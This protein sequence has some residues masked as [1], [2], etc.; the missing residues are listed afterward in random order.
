M[1]FNVYHLVAMEDI[2]ELVKFK[3]EQSVYFGLLKNH[4]IYRINGDIFSD[5]IVTEEKYLLDDVKVL[6]PCRP[7][8]VIGIGL[9][10][11]DAIQK[12]K[13]AIPKEP[14]VFL[15]PPSSIIGPYDPI[16]YPSMSDMVTYEVELAVIIG[17]KAKNISVDNAMD[18][19][20]GYTVANDVT[21]KDLL[22][23]YG[24]WDIG[25]GFDTFL[26]LGPYIVTDIDPRNL[27]ITMKCNDVTTQNSNTDQ[28]IFDVSELISYTSHVMTLMPGDVIIT[29]TPAGASELNIGDVLEGN[30]EGLGTIK[31]TVVGG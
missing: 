7:S 17:K 30:I 1:Y 31:N 8:K 22:G 20:F 23:K 2:M 11:K 19:V 25:K 3:V 29:G 15:K 28:M 6:A 24:P 9:N 5:Y 14:I 13:T 21:A 10:Y 27:K 4:H 16:V 26:P 18:Y 12:A